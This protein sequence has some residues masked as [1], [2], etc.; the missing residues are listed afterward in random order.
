MKKFDIENIYSIYNKYII[1]PNSYYERFSKINEY[2]S[3][4]ELIKYK[5][6]DPP[7]VVSI[8]DFKEWIEKFNIKTGDKLLYTCES[9]AELCYI[10]Y[11][12]K[13][14][15]PYPPYDLHNFD[16]EEKNHDLVI[17]NQTIEHLYNPFEAI[18][19]IYEI[20][21]PGGYVFTSV[22]TINIPHNTP[23]HF[24]G[25]TPM[26]LAML[27]K[28]ANFQPVIKICDFTGKELTTIK[29]HDGF[30]GKRIA[31]VSCIDWNYYKVSLNKYLLSIFNIL[32]E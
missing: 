1:K 6:I 11:S 12:N 10:D 4:S 27:F 21:K 30:L 29:H 2:L 7:R 9:D 14:Y 26:G 15:L 5:N 28:S 22:P 24:N 31:P 25:F 19:Q 20:V 3:E 16:I 18:K 8:I 17:F 32:N 13:T 23:I